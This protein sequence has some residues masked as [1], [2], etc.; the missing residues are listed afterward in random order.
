MRKAVAILAFAMLAATTFS[1]QAQMFKCLS[2]SGVISYSDK[3]CAPMAAPS[4][5]GGESFGANVLIVK[6]HPEIESWVMTEPAKR[7]G[8]VGRARSVTRGTKFYL[9]VVATFSQSQEGQRIALV[10]DLEIVA[11]GGKVAKISSCCSANRVDPRAPATIVLNPVVDLTFDATDPTGEY[12]VRAMINNG[13][14]TVVAEEI[15]RL[16]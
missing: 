9:P 12:K 5:K 15:F 4:R 13:K 16:Q 2:E 14:E 7:R 1:A 8:N 3:P 11:P 10:A 6:S